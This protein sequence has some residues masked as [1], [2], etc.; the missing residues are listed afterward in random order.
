MVHP[1]KDKDGYE[2]PAHA[3]IAFETR[4]SREAFRV[5]FHGQRYS[6]NKAD[7]P[8]ECRDVWEGKITEDLRN[9]PR[10]HR[11]GGDLS[12][13]QGAVAQPMAQPMAPLPLW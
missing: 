2:R 11:K 4:A 10:Y 6:I 5:K 1:G 8:L 13:A 12:K 7:K 3:I 9:A